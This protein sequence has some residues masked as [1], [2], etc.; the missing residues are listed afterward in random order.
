VAGYAFCAAAADRIAIEGSVVWQIY[1]ELIASVPAASTVSDV[2]IGQGWVA[3]RSDGM[4]MAMAQREGGGS[5]EFSGSPRGLKTRDVAGWIKSW[6]FIEA[7]IGLAAI[8][9]AVNRPQAVERHWGLRLTDSPSQDLFKFIRPLIAGKKVTVV[10]HFPDL[11]R[12]KTCCR[13]SILERHPQP[14]DY[15]DSACEYILADQDMIV[16]TATTLIN[17]TMPRLLQLGRHAEIAV[18][19]PSTPLLPLLFDH[20][21]TLMGGLVIEDEARAWRGV[22]EGLDRQILNEGARMVNIPKTQLRATG[23][24]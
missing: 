5:R 10:G 3:V 14:G 16:M 2:M 7:A 18:C 17:K 11:E 15:P 22:Q 21:V 23:A 9:S 13:L 8:N 6:N 1:D 20:G 12:M 24:A 19:G 4:G